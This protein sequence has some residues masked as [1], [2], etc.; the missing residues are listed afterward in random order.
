MNVLKYVAIA[1]AV[2][3]A[4]TVASA[5]SLIN[6][7]PLGGSGGGFGN[8]VN[9]LTAQHAGNNIHETACIYGLWS[10]P[11]TGCE[12]STFPYSFP[13]NSTQNTSQMRDLTSEPVLAGISG[14]SAR[15]ILNISENQNDPQVLLND[16]RIYLFDQS[17]ALKFK[18]QGYNGLM[19][20]SNGTGNFGV[21]FGLSAPD[22]GLFDAAVADGGRW[23]G[24]G[25]SMGFL[26]ERTGILFGGVGGGPESI[27]LAQTVVVPEPSTYAL[28][29][30]G[31]LGLWGVARRRATS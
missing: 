24:A 17:G 28:M 4:P 26:P 27:S 10:L 1:A 22:V 13:D 8:V 21:V 5:Q 29:A 9:L 6:Y 2:V 25:L 16:M 19:I 3:F 20:G 18:S 23:F 7:G 30:V 12:L 31:L 11:D 15:F 14:A